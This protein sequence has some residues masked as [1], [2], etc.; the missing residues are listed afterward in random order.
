MNKKLLV[1]SVEHMN[2]MANASSVIAGGLNND[3]KRYDFSFQNNSYQEFIKWEKF[4]FNSA[5]SHFILFKRMMW[6]QK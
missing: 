4:L 1:D 2:S 5:V 6:N 3:L